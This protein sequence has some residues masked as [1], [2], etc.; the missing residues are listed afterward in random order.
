MTIMQTHERIMMENWTFQVLVSVLVHRETESP[1]QSTAMQR[2]NLLLIVPQIYL[3]S[4][5][6]EVLGF[7]NTKSTLK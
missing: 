3:F 5:F 4:F 1:K 2:L 7:F 6:F